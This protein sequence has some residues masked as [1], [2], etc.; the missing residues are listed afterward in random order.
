M[1]YELTKAEKKIARVCID[2]AL[3]EEFKE[4]LN[5][6]ESILEDWK[7][8]KFTTNKEAYH[9]LFKAVDKN[10]DAIGRRYDDLT[11]SRYLMTVAAVLHDGYITENDIK[12]FSEHAKAWINK[13]INAWQ[14]E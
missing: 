10:E 7:Q 1:Y 4:G 12:G 13:W 6:F 14:S 8:G 11:G 9:A 5:Q 2:K 3:D